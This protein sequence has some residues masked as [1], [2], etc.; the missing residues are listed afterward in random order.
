MKK[1][2][3]AIAV[4]IFL[5]SAAPVNAAWRFGDYFPRRTPTPRVYPT[6]VQ[7]TS[8]SARSTEKAAN[9]AVRTQAVVTRML[10]SYQNRLDNYK[11]FLAKVKLR[12]DK[13]AADGKDVA[14]LDAFILRATDNAAN[15]ESVLNSAKTAL[16]LLDYTMDMKELRRAIQTELRKIRLAFTQMHKSMS[17]NVR[18]IREL[19]LRS[20]IAPTRTQPTRG[21]FP[22]KPGKRVG[23]Q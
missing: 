20:T 8:A 7:P 18:A 14:R 22:T 11:D 23:Q 5:F 12:R 17:E 16:G 21:P 2:G 13:L 1:A 3:I 6:R 19:S 15:A 9:L 4:L 10:N